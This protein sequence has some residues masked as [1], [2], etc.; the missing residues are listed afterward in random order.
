VQLD[1]LIL[2]VNDLNVSVDFYT[3]IL[4]LAHEGQQGPFAV[5][6][7]SADFTIQLAAWGTE[8]GE[9]LAFALAAAQ[10]DAVFERLRRAAI[11]YGD[12]FHEVG[13][14]K[15]PGE[16]AGARGMAKSIYFLDPNQHLLEI[17][18]YA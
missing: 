4:G 3:R 12:S 14:M 2:R 17:R 8:G 11:P 7:V 9:H 15:G 13:N 5:V 18:C 16:E 6:R 1:H 10:F